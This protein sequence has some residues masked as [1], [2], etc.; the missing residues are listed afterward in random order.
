MERF[1]PAVNKG[2][3]E[4]DDASNGHQVVGCFHGLIKMPH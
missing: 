3:E 2:D 1:V 4:S